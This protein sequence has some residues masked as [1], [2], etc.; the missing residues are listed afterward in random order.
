MSG[1]KAW[2]TAAMPNTVPTARCSLTR[3]TA[4]VT[5]A[6]LSGNENPAATPCTIRMAIKDSAFGARP[7]AS[8]DS[9]NATVPMTNHRRLPRRSPTRPPMIS[10]APL[11][12]M[13]PLMT[14][15]R[16]VTDVSRSRAISGIAACTAKKSSSIRNTPRAAATIRRHSRGSCVRRRS[17]ADVAVTARFS[18]QGRGGA[19]DVGAS[20]SILIRLSR[21]Q[22]TYCECDQP[23][24]PVSFV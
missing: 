3:G 15:C 8:D 13:Y 24:W 19:P 9:P 14:H 6:R 16:S 2:P 23:R 10:V 18:R 4:F 21:A 11:A 1:P 7:P 12:S 17:F 20:S 5:T 22:D